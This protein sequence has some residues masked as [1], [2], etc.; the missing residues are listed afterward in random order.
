MAPTLTSCPDCCALSFARVDYKCN[1]W[2]VTAQLRRY[3]QEVETLKMEDVNKHCGI[4]EE[5]LNLFK[6]F[7]ML[8]LNCADSFNLISVI[9]QKS[10]NN[11]RRWPNS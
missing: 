1:L 11:I 2:N 9:R 8:E 10:D 5:T 4:V 7:N 6:S 3:I